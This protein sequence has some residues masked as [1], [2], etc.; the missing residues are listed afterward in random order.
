MR[1]VH[2]FRLW[3]Q[4]PTEEKLVFTATVSMFDNDAGTTSSWQIDFSGRGLLCSCFIGAPS[5]ANHACTLPMR[6][7]R[8]RSSLQGTELKAELKRTHELSERKHTL[9]F[10]FRA[11]ILT[12]SVVSASSFGFIS[13]RR[14]S[15]MGMPP[16]SHCTSALLL[17]G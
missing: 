5:S 16:C 14:G 11:A 6:Y 10:S 2:A 15:T 8:R 13:R 12:F 7:P 4:A 3:L 9:L 1:R 17:P